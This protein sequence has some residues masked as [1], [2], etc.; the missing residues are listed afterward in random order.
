MTFVLLGSMELYGRSRVGNRGGANEILLDFCFL[1][2]IAQEFQGT[3][4]DLL[5]SCIKFGNSVVL[6]G[7]SEEPYVASSRDVEH[8]AWKVFIY[9]SDNSVTTWPVVLGS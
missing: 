4:R 1:N 6:G 8:G 3:I 7:L 2:G 9:D 5:R